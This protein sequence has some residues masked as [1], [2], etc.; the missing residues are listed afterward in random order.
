M[1]ISM[2]IYVYICMYISMYIYPGVRKVVTELGVYG[3]TG[4]VTITYTPR[5]AASDD[6]ACCGARDIRKPMHAAGVEPVY[7]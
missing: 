5:T 4:S 2:Y 3:S 6:V 7:I 1:Y